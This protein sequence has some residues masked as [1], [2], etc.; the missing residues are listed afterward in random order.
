[1]ARSGGLAHLARQ[2]FADGL[3]QT[4]LVAAGFGVVGAV[5][6]FAFVR[7]RPAGKV[8]AGSDREQVSAR[9]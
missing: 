1:M 8:P 4:F 7:P 3:D 5:L 9:A 6:V 2:A